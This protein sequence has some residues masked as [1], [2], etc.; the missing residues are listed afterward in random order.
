MFPRPPHFSI[1][2]VVLEV[3]N[4]VRYEGHLIRSDDARLPAQHGLPI[5]Q[6]IDVI[7]QI[8]ENEMGT[9]FE[10]DDSAN[11]HVED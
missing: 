1:L 7:Y 8:L 3:G 6:G 9:P 4:W 11:L 5:L 2:K 10:D